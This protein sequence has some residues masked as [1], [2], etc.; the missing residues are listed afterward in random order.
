MAGYLSGVKASVEESLSSSSKDSGFAIIDRAQAVEYMPKGDLDK[1][2]ADIE[3]KCKAILHPGPKDTPAVID[4][5]WRGWCDRLRIDLAARFYDSDADEVVT[6]QHIILRSTATDTAVKC[7]LKK[8]LSEAREDAPVIRFLERCLVGDAESK[9]KLIRELGKLGD[10]ID[11]TSAQDEITKLVIAAVR[12]ARI[13]LPFEEKAVEVCV[14]VCVCVCWRGI[15]VQRRVQTYRH[16]YTNVHQYCFFFG[17]RKHTY[18]CVC[19]CVC[20]HVYM[21]IYMYIYIY[22]YTYTRAHTHTG[23]Q[24]P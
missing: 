22:I 15:C 12:E 5:V 7:L 3:S 10:V 18:V 24:Y 6:F 20:I 14:C 21:C 17:H 19:V 9:K 13:D 8:G 16:T 1:E 23:Q 11:G 2:L 4:D